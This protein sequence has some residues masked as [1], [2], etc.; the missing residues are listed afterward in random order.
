MNPDSDPNRR[1]DP[2]PSSNS[3]SSLNPHRSLT[4]VGR[5]RCARAHKCAGANYALAPLELW[6]CAVTQARR[7]RRRLCCAL[8]CHCKQKRRRLLRALLRAHPSRLRQA[9]CLAC[10]QG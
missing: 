6:V 2:S 10:E 4:H 3:N 7:T 9:T 1:P 5:L 8:A